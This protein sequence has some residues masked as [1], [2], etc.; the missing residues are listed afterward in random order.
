MALAAALA[1]ASLGA[2]AQLTYPEDK[3]WDNRWYVAPFVQFVFPDAAR[4]AKNGVGYGV[5]LGKPLTPSWDLELRGAWESL[6]ADGAPS[7]WRNW[8]FEADA[9]WYFLGRQGVAKWDGL[10]PYLVGGLGAIQD[11]VGGESKLSGLVVGGAGV[12]L[13]LGRVARFTLDGRYRWENNGGKL[14]SNSA[15]GDWLLTVGVSIPFGA[16]PAVAQPVVAAAPP[17]PPAPVAQARPVPPPVVAP[18]PPLTRTFD[19]SADGMFAF[20]KADLTPVGKSRIENMIEGM[21]QAGITGI[22]DITVIGHTD[23][24]G[25]AEFNEQLSRE[26]ANAVRDYLVTRGIPPSVIK[27]EGRGESQLRIT[28]EQC[29]AKGQASPRSTLIACLAPN[30]RV[31]VIATAVQSKAQP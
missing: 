25:T 3:W 6:G 29:R 1:G 31:E 14:V 21:R 11:N 12:A 9:K 23:P 28:E 24:I 10:Q 4:E 16:A 5:A 19:I 18:P 22:K 15:F 2:Q 17:P 27:A 20:G 8:T 7:D 26:R 13:P 30:R